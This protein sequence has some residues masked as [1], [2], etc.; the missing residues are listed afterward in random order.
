VWQVGVLFIFDL[1]VLLNPVQVLL[2]SLDG[3]VLKLELGVGDGE[4][5][6]AD[7][8]LQHYVLWIKLNY[9]QLSAG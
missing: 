8:L 1:Y 4:V 7:N 2:L 3:H 5:G 9:L 6:V